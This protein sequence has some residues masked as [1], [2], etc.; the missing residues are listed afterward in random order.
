M[1]FEPNINLHKICFKGFGKEGIKLKI[2][3]SIQNNFICALTLNSL[4]GD[5]YIIN[6]K[7]KIGYNEKIGELFCYD[8][9]KLEYKKLNFIE[10]NLIIYWKEFF[11]I[12][13][14][15]IFFNLECK[16]NIN[17]LIKVLFKTF[18]KYINETYEINIFKEFLKLIKN[19]FWL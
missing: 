4:F 15:N 6:R 2:C 13:L 16:A 18:N 19:K 14:P 11:L 7:I 1:F 8:F 3:L 12:I 9:V 5:L 17:I 10:L